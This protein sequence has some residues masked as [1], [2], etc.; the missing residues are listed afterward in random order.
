[1][2]LSEAV[3]RECMRRLY[4]LGIKKAYITGWNDTTNGL[5]EKLGSESKK[6]WF[7]FEITK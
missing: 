4:S 7:V 1:M 2:G 3:I 5:Y 6:D